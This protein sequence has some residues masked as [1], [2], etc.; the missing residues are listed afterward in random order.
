MPRNDASGSRP[1]S[2]LPQHAR[3][4]EHHPADDDNPNILIGLKN[5]RS[6]DIAPSD[7]TGGPVDFKRPENRNRSSVKNIRGHMGKDDQKT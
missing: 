1:F 6:H 4:N 3:D 2:V 5:D 7:I